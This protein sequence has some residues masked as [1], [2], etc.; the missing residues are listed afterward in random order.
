MQYRTPYKRAQGK[1][2]S[3]MKTSPYLS[4][5]V[6]LFL[7]FS[8]SASTGLHA[9]TLTYSVG[10]VAGDFKANVLAWLGNEPKTV[11][12]RSNFVASAEKR[13]ALSLQA[14][15]YY[16]PDISITVD[17]TNSIWKMVIE[18]T[19]KKPVIVS[20]VDI[21][22]LGAARDDPVFK[23]LISE[24]SIHLGDTFNH[25]KY[26]TLK[27]RVLVLGKKRGYFD[28]TLIVSRVDV[29]VRARSANILLHYASGQRYRFGDIRYDQGVTSFG[30]LQAL[31]T[32]KEHDYYDL[33]LVQQFQANLQRTNF[34]SSVLLRPLLDETRDSQVPMLLELQPAK[35][36]GFDIG[37]GY[38]TDTRGRISLIW[39]TPRI[40][41]YG[42]SQETR[43]KYSDINP[44]A[45]VTY[46]IPLSHPL[47]D[48][49][50][51][52][53]RLETDEYGD[54]ESDQQELGVL[55]E[56]KLS[57]GWLRGYSLRLLDEEWDV[58]S[59]S[60]ESYYTLPG[61][62]FSKRTYKGSPV[63]PQ[64]GASRFYQFELASE[65]VASEISLLRAYSKLTYVKS[66]GDRHRFVTRGE[67]GAVFIKDEDRSSLSPS[68]GFIAGGSQSI[69]GFS[70]N[71]IGND[72]RVTLSDGSKTTLTTGGDRLLIASLE[73]QYR[74]LENWRGAIFT[75]YGDAFNKNNFEA[76]YSAGF[77][78]HYLTPVGAVR[79]EIANSLSED[80]P[81]WYVHLNIG[82]EF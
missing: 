17:E 60:E 48:T 76:N 8:S 46:K 2:S 33:S 80:D 49:L 68:L 9:E 37:L 10:G 44:S 29:S 45:R 24:Q 50:A 35:R 65:K 41:R 18:I 53:A 12:E 73:Y 36:H 21:K 40:N 39:R 32:F 62:T 66:L 15:G 67:L 34:Y 71:S 11:A 79:A 72:V 23:K 59:L 54:L 51:L 69:R 75:D 25:G 57:N 20:A 52:K 47:D 77:G 7:L 43:L 1:H 5:A 64:A 81:S 58:G 61:I 31:G 26:E 13:V 27:N 63:N 14:L 55:R 4:Y 42:H 30:Q 82:A 74:F 70:Y 3:K 56:M 38:S 19:P 16:S 22:L 78:I 28:G 6:L